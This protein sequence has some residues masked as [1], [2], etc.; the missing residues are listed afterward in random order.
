VI[1]SG[2]ATVQRREERLL[3]ERLADIDAKVDRLVREVA[4]APPAPPQDPRVT[5]LARAMGD[6][7]YHFPSGAQVS[8]T[9][10]EN[11]EVIA[12]GLTIENRFW[13]ISDIM[14]LGLINERGA[15]L[16]HR[17]S[18]ISHAL[19]PVSADYLRPHYAATVAGR[20]S[21]VARPTITLPPITILLEMTGF[22]SLTEWLA[23]PLPK[24]HVRA[25][26]PEARQERKR[27]QVRVCKAKARRER[28]LKK[29]ILDLSPRVLGL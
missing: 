8:L 12:T 2:N 24:E 18:A 19:P 20:P 25:L 9:W 6:P 11:D 1:H 17:Y 7:L 29:I 3:R 16:W 22:N 21:L 27:A 26:S 5:T 28:Q 14:K 15:W 10:D 13:S 23:R 4:K